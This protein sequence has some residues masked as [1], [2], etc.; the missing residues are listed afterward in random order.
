MDLHT[1]IP[2]EF[3]HIGQPLCVW[4]IRMKIPV[5]D[6]L[7]QVLRIGSVARAAVVA[8]LNGRTNA[9]GAAE[10]QNP[11]VIHTDTVVMF[12]IVPDTSV[13]FIRVLCMN[14]LDFLGK[15]RIVSVALA[16]FP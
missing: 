5:Q 8:V 12:Q 14:L 7:C 1:F 13:S 2:L 16:H 9:L 3:R 4:L 11:L 15:P 6:I 10:A